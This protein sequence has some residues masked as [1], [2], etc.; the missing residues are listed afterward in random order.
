MLQSEGLQTQKP[1]ILI[2]I[3]FISFSFN[4]NMRKKNHISC[5]IL[6]KIKLQSTF[7]SP[8][9]INNYFLRW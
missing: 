7:E 5:S 2:K 6:F 8:S 4:I 1:Y 9:S 3:E